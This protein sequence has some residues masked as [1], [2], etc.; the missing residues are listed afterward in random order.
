MIKR[1]SAIK[2]EEGRGRAWIRL[3]LNEKIL[4]ETFERLINNQKVL[5]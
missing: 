5:K 3:A 1:L 4:G 2:T